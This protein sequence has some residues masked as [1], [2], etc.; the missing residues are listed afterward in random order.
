MT[1]PQPTAL[2]NYAKT[3]RWL[4]ER[5]RAK[6]TS[7]SCRGA[8]SSNR[9]RQCESLPL[10]I[11]SVSAFRFLETNQFRGWSRRMNINLI[12]SDR[13]QRAND[14]LSASEAFTREPPTH[15]AEFFQPI[16]LQLTFGCLAMACFFGWSNL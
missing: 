12:L 3:E 1:P 6:M 8:R 7:S 15:N 16:T 9:E 13:I 14:A 4:A 2:T 5:V 11:A 10:C